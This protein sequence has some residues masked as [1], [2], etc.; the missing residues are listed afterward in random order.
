M[1]HSM[2]AALSALTMNPP[3]TTVHLAAE[4]IGETA[5]ELLLEQV[6]GRELHKRVTLATDIRWRASTRFPTA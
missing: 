2:S 4:E 6:G 5:V 1:G 3:L